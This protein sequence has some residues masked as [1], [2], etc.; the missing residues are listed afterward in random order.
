MRC[1]DDVLILHPH[2]QRLQAFQQRPRVERAERRA[3]VPHQLLHRLVDVLLGRRGSPRRA[4]GPGRRCAWCPST[5]RRRRP[6]AN[7]AAGVGVAKT[8][9]STTFAPAACARSQT[10]AMSTSDCIGLDGVSKN[11]AWVGTDSA[12]SHCDE[13]VAV[14]E[15]R[16]DAP[17]RQDLVAHHEARTEQ[18]ARGHQPVAGAEQ[19]AQRVNTAAMP[20]GGREARRCALDQPQPL[21]EHRDRRVAVTG[22]DIAVDLAGERLLRVGRRR[23]DVPRRQVHRLG[24]LL[25]TRPQQAAAHSDGVL[26]DAVWQFAG[27]RTDGLRRS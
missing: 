27:R 8:L 22:V 6:A 14:D 11:T 25:E 2:R 13:V 18:A 15:D 3:G 24:G 4:P 7:P 26:A 10:A 20:G 23:V 1:A 19:R 16:L 9:S 17:A 5:R 21:L 12:S